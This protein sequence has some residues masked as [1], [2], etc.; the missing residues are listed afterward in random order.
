[1]NG[2]PSAVRRLGYAA[3]EARAARTR[4]AMMAQERRQARLEVLQRLQRGEI[5]ADQAA[6]ELEGAR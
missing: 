2:F 3:M 5:T 4:E 6:A 1:M